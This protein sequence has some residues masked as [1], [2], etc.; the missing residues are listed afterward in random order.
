MDS[1]EGVEGMVTP[2]Q[3]FNLEENS[4]QGVTHSPQG[5]VLNPHGPSAPS[6]AAVLPNAHCQQPPVA[7]QALPP[8][9]EMPANIPVVVHGQTPQQVLPGQVPA[10]GYQI[11]GQ[12]P[13]PGYQG[14]MAAQPGY[15]MGQIPQQPGY[16][17][18]MPP[19]PKGMPSP[20]MGPPPH[21]DYMGYSG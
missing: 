6:I 17:G 9:Q 11:Q 4:L 10:Q 12:V 1:E 3:S 15:P 20:P 5:A 8:G 16:Q 21:Y 18:Q 14:Q 19:Q 2:L 7:Q 13:Q